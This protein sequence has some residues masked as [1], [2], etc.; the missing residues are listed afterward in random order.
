LRK[1]IRRGIS[2]RDIAR[3]SIARR[4]G[5]SKQSDTLKKIGGRLSKLEGSKFKKP[6]HVEIDDEDEEKIRMKGIR[7]NMEGISNL[8]KSPRIPWP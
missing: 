5:Y 6:I 4:K 3:V 8:R 1:H 7:P 2:R